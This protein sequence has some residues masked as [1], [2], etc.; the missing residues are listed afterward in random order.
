MFTSE[1]I[2]KAWKIRREAARKYN[3]AVSVISWKECLVMAKETVKESL[4]AKIIENFKGEVMCSKILECLNMCNDVFFKE[5]L[6]DNRPQD[7]LVFFLKHLQAGDL[8]YRGLSSNKAMKL[9]SNGEITLL[10][11]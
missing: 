9:N 5:C 6:V 7:N 4:K 11:R 10:E 8:P 3:C 1:L 2:K